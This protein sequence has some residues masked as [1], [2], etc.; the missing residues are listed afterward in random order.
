M[1]DPTA[2]LRAI[3]D[4]HP[5]APFLFI[6]SGFS[7]RYLGLEDWA[8]LL[9]R[10]CK[11][12]KEFSYY[13]AKA[14]NNL[15]LAATYMAEDYYEWWW[16]SN[17]TSASRDEFASSVNDLAD[18]LKYEIAKYLNSFSLIDVQLSS[19]TDEIS[20]FADISVDGIITTNWDSLIEESFPDY[21]V[22]VGQ[23][24]LLFSNPQSIAE[25][26][27]IHGTASDPRSMVLAEADYDEFTAKNPYLAAKLVTIF[28]EH[29][30]V[31]MGYSI[32]DP[33]IQSI[34]SS[35]AQCLP[36]EKIP[37]FEKNLIFI[38]R[39]EGD[40]QSAMERATLQSGSFSVSLT[41]AS[42]PD[43]S[44]VYS[45]LSGRKRKVPARLLRFFKEQMYDFVQAPEASS[46]K[47][48]VIDFDRLSENDDIEFVVGVGVASRQEKLN[49]A[50]DDALAKRGYAGVTADDIFAD[51]VRVDSAFEASSL[52]EGAYPALARSH[53]TFLPVFRYLR[54]AGIVQ[55]E[56]LDASSFIG[57]RKVARKVIGQDYFLSSA[58]RGRFD[59]Y[60]GNLGTS[61]IINNAASKKEA[62]LMLPFQDHHMIDIAALRAF[63][64]TNAAE[65]TGP[66]YITAYRKLVCL[67]DKLAFG[68]AT[69]D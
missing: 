55:K 57:A 40:E 41:V 5:A 39:T 16:S 31:F 61:D 6:G 8:G 47:L 44:Q 12:I 29:P 49:T 68:F 65:F 37:A 23:S 15:P 19:F 54:S 42:V 66:P 14:G 58:Y 27:K 51:I 26:Y 2:A 46:T 30:I 36:Q 9:S 35:I 18:P 63:L 7:R 22:Y 21:T 60:F 1:T 67:Y 13:R 56:A 25:I 17:D 33:H 43:F 52:L 59:Q 28:V 10:F 3:F 32:N 62:L 34:I 69:E 38:R 50:I 20:A 11:P 48:A 45:S 24:E 53:R 4:E 64:E